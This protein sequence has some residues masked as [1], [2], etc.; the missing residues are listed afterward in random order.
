MRLNPAAQWCL[1]RNAN[2]LQL[3]KGF[4]SMKRLGIIALAGVAA[5]GGS[6]AFAQRGITPF[7]D[8]A[9]AQKMVVT[10]KS[11][12]AQC[13]AHYPSGDGVRVC[14][15]IS[16]VTMMASITSTPDTFSRNSG[17]VQNLCN[18]AFRPDLQ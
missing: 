11:A 8:P 12:E 9:L 1:V 13:E 7:D 15:C 4:L 3:N 16:A 5:V 14:G 2:T 6:V 17:I 10:L 18:K